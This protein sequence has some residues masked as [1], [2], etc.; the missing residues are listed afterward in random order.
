MLHNHHATSTSPARRLSRWL[1][2]ALLLFLASLAC[3]ELAV[4]DAT[5]IAPPTAPLGG[6]TSPPV[7][8][9]YEIAEV[10][11]VIDGDTI[12]VA[13]DGEVYRVRYIG[14]NTPERDEACYREATEAN[15]DLVA[16]QTVTLVRDVSETDRYGRLLRYVYV[17]DTFVNAVLVAGGWAEAVV[18]EP[19]SAQYDYL[20]ALEAD[21]AAQGLGCWPTGVFER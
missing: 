5:V 3:G 17:G 9:D 14:V 20:D 21:A 4:D 13:I 19:D 10:V 1:L 15:T 7:E 6:P 2:P 8:T 18:Y 16:Y 12:D 11:R